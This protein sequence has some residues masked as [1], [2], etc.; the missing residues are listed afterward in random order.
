MAFLFIQSVG[1][2]PF[3]RSEAGTLLHKFKLE[4]DAITICSL[5]VLHVNLNSGG[6]VIHNVFL[7]LL[8]INPSLCQLSF[9]YFW[10]PYSSLNTLLQCT[11]VA[12]RIYLNVR[13]HG[14]SFSLGNILVLQASSLNAEK[15]QHGVLV[16]NRITAFYIR[17]CLCTTPPIA[18]FQCK[19]EMFNQLFISNRGLL[20]L[21]KMAIYFTLLSLTCL[22]L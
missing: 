16:G 5:L 6:S 22:S 8:L 19:K 20:I 11:A 4:P 21:C 2:C 1:V 14:D 10:L 7:K 13:F 15:G 9:H 3:C 17:M 18:A 12:T